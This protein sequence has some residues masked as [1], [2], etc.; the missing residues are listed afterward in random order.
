MTLQTRLIV[1]LCLL[2]IAFITG[3]TINGWRYD[4]KLKAQIEAQLKNKDASE[5]AAKILVKE[6]QDEKAKNLALYDKLKGKVN[7][8]TDNRVCFADWDAVRLWNQGLLG[9]GDVPSNTA[10]A[11]GPTG[12]PANVTDRD[13]LNNQLENARRWK[14]LRDQV[15]KLRT[16][17]DETFNK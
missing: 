8:V 17:N 12:S 3:W 15:N 4:A 5:Q 9:A 16:W 7:H 10:G 14:N 6:L 11:T 1:A 13:L 2:M